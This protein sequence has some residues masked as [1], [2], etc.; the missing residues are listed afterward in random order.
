VPR[1]LIRYL[2]RVGD[3]VLDPFVGSG[4]TALAAVELGRRVIGF[5]QSA[6]Y[7]ESAKRRLLEA[8]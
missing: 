6:E 7:I 2:C 3:V 4:T 5:D 1:R 8:H